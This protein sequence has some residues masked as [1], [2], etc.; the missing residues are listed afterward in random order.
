MVEIDLQLA[1][2]LITATSVTIAA[3]FYVINLRETTKNRK[4]TL[5]TTLMHPFCMTEEGMRL[6]IDLTAM[7][8]KDIEDFKAKYD[9]RVN[10]E[11][12]SKRFAF[13][14]M[15][16]NFGR[17]YREG[18]IDLET[19]YGGS[20]FLIQISWTKFKPVIEA[21][22]GGDFSVNHLE[23]WEYLAGKLNEFHLKKTGEDY[24]AKMESILAGHGE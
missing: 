19:L 13:W 12:Y 23:N 21:Y 11:N 17:L 6:F 4:I 24:N 10:P 22:R 3:I 7:N 8:W 2:V 5:T 14:N 18:L 15:C 9:S 16:E 1:G 20:N